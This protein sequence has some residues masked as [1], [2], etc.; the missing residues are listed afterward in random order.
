MLDP[1]AEIPVLKFNGQNSILPAEVDALTREVYEHNQKSIVHLAVTS[2][3]GQTYTG[4]GVLVK[5]GDDVVIVTNGHVAA[6]PRSIEVTNAAGET[7]AARLDK[8]D[9]GDDLATLKPD[10]IKID[11]SMALAIGDSTKLTAGQM[12]YAMSHPRG[13]DQPVMAWGTM[14]KQDGYDKVAPDTADLFRQAASYL[15]PGNNGYLSAAEKF[16]TVARTEVPIDHGGSG[17][18]LLDK[19]S[20]LVGILESQPE[21][22]PNGQSVSVP[23]DRVQ[24]ML[25]DPNYKFQFHYTRKSLAEL[26]PVVTTAK[27]FGLVGLAAS[28]ATQRV[29]APLIGL[30]YGA[31]ALGD[32]RLLSHDNLYQSR[33]HYWEKFAADSG[34]CAAGLLSLV[35]RLRLAGAAI[36]ATRLAVDTLTDF[37]QSKPELDRVDRLDGS[38]GEPLFWSISH[39]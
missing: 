8:F 17:G 14:T 33:A 25:N 24:A 38:K 39:K 22:K 27:G 36:V 4:S 12:L 37:T 23:A 19:N 11:P 7:F 18:A 5:Q 28:P 20:K 9:E 1:H 34:T 10:G 15:Y 21:A 2:P 30:Y 29:A 32:L 13:Y 31:Q 6:K 26:A 16:T 35:P 3:D